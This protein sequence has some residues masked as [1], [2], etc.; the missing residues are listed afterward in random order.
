[1]HCLPTSSP[2]KKCITKCDNRAAFQN[3]TDDP[4]GERMV[5]NPGRI[6]WS[7]TKK[8]HTTYLYTNARLL[9]KKMEELELLL[10]DVEDTGNMVE[11]YSW[12]QLNG[13][14]KFELLRKEK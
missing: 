11:Q 2:H 4:V 6:Q 10:E 3:E 8:Q 12:L 5:C 7:V 13:I 14:D 9:S 1:M